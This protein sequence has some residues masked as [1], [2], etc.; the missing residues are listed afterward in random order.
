M[1]HEKSDLRYGLPAVW[2]DQIGEPHVAFSVDWA[3]FSAFNAVSVKCCWRRQA[4]HWLSEIDTVD[5]SEHA[6]R[7][8]QSVKRGDIVYLRR[9]Y[10]IVLSAFVIAS[11]GVS[12]RAA[13]DPVASPK[14]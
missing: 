5:C 4:E 6:N 8:V 9:L 14:K 3:A 2:A 7:T 10:A 1:L 13:S 11:A 12:I